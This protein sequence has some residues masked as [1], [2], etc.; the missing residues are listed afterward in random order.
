LTSTFQQIVSLALILLVLWL[1][2]SGII[3]AVINFIIANPLVSLIII[4]VLI[5]VIYILGKRFG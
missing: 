1:V 4:A 3:Q 5:L 2:W